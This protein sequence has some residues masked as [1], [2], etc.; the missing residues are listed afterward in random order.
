[1][2]AWLTGWFLPVLYHRSWI[3]VPPG[4]H[5]GEAVAARAV[6]RCARAAGHAARAVACPL[7]LHPR[8]WIGLLVGRWDIGLAAREAAFLKWLH[9]HSNTAASQ[10]SMGAGEPV[11]MHASATHSP[12]GTLCHSK[13]SALG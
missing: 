13:H 9:A 12:S 3:K 5:S 10:S 2:G 7:Y 11:Y 6:A 8:T 4:Q 1:M